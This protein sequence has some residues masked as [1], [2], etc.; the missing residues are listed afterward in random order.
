VLFSGTIFDNVAYGLAGTEHAD[1]SYENKMVLV[2]E[3]FKGA[4]AHEFIQDLPKQYDT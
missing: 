2:K 1:A 3:A 4:Y